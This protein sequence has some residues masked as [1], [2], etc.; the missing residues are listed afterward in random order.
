MRYKPDGTR[1][2]DTTVGNWNGGPNLA[3]IEWENEQVGQ[4]RAYIV[5]G[6]GTD[7]VAS[8]NKCLVVDFY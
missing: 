7:D 2:L 5:G 6:T 8:A 3:A 1:A 4:R